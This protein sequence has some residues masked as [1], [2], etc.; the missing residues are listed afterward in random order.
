MPRRRGSHGDLPLEAN[1]NVTSLVDVAFTLLVIFIITA[2]ILQG[3]VEVAVPRADVQPLTAQD[4]PFFVSVTADGRIWVEEDEWTLE[5]FREGIPG[6]LAAGG[7]ERVYLRGDSAARYGPM[8]QV[9]TIIANT[10]VRPAL[11]AEPW[12]GN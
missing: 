9:F 2:P 6:V 3:G 10:G 5:Q 11:V 7:I 12:K 8:L 4:D 1:I